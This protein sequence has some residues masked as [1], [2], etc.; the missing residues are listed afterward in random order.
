MN[1]IWFRLYVLDKLP[2]IVLHKHTN[3]HQILYMFMYTYRELAFNVLCTGGL[4]I[5]GNRSGSICPSHALKK[6]T[7]AK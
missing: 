2:V 5:N 7:I 1:K 3:A 4:H 6:K